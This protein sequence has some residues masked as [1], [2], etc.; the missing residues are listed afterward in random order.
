[1]FKYQVLNLI[2]Q[3]SDNMLTGSLFLGN[4]Q[5]SGIEMKVVHY[6]WL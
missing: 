3:G 6:R 2:I 5:G 4:L 1:M